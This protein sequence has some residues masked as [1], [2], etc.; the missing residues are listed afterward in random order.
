MS[1]IEFQADSCSAEDGNRTRKG[2]FQSGSAHIVGLFILR[3]RGSIDREGRASVEFP[4]RADHD[5][6]G[7]WH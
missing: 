4:S 7:R 2:A 6:S 3:S 1:L 5:L